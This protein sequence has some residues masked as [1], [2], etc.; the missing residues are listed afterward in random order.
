MNIWCASEIPFEELEGGDS[1]EHLN[2]MCN[3]V[4]RFEYKFP[5]VKLVPYLETYR[6]YRPLYVGGDSEEQSS[7]FPIVSRT[8]Y[9]KKRMCCEGYVLS[10]ASCVPR[11]PQS[12]E[13]GTCKEPDVCT[14]NEGYHMSSNGTCLPKCSNGCVNGTC[15]EPELC[16]CHNGYWLDSDGFT[17]L[18]VCQQQ[19]G[20][21]EYC[22]EPNVCT[23]RSG[24]MRTGIDPYPSMC[25][26]ICDE[27]C[28]LG[29]C[30]AP[31]TCTCDDGHRAVNA[32]VCEPILPICEHDCITSE[33]N[34]HCLPYV[35][36]RCSCSIGFERRKVDF[37][38]ICRPICG[39]GFVNDE[40]THIC[41]PHC[42]PRCRP[43]TECTSPN[44][45]TCS[46]GYQHVPDRF[47]IYG[48]G[49]YFK[50]AS[51]SVQ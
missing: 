21:H 37:K 12:C 4:N 20:Y 14:C 50:R 34:S 5:L 10:G 2:N 51:I 24:Y 3:K 6:R 26:P 7:W 15:I 16:S 28:V 27:P 1:K 47:E 48:V 17:C 45:C 42:E 31:N 43:T 23:C 30:T 18:S 13:K 33:F 38:D 49:R 22:S 36:E 25:K 11:C 41:K 32:S 19:C 39:L 8:N 35:P 9:R 40:T 46:K 29:K 44:K